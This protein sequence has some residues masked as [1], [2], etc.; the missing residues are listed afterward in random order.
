MNHETATWLN[1]IGLILGFISFWF[2]APEFIGEQRLKTWEESLAN[3]TKKLPGIFAQVGG[4]FLLIGAI[5]FLGVVLGI[6]GV[7]V[8]E[9]RLMVTCI[10][11]V[12]VFGLVIMLFI[13]YWVIS[14]PLERLALRIVSVLA[15]D[16]KQRQRSLFIGGG[17]FIISFLLQFFATFESAT[18]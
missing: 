18:K 4:F 10:A 1:R 9:H 6:L 2:A 12:Y 11:S 14:D 15:N 3:L 7:N 8:S 5:V 16:R 17:L 13:Y